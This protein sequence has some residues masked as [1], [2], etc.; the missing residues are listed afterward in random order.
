[1]EP[2]GIIGYSVTSGREFFYLSLNRE[3][4][5]RFSFTADFG[6]PHAT[7]SEK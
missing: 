3:L 5:N 7:F 6:G 2:I 4:K 1:M